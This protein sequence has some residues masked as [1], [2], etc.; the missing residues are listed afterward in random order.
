MIKEVSISGSLSRLINVDL[1][2]RLLAERC[3]L[4]DVIPNASTWCS[5][6]VH[7]VHMVL[8]W[9]SHSVHIVFTWFSQ[10]SRGVHVVFTWCSRGVH[11][12]FIC[13]ATVVWL[14][15]HGILYMLCCS[16][17]YHAQSELM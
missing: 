13:T 4:I 5:R 10:C 3:S 11:V 9:C 6:G 15:E 16:K 8:T 14:P 17:L 2:L 7:S 1:C 12:V